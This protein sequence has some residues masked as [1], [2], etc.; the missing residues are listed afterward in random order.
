MQI[1]IETSHGNSVAIS[2]FLMLVRDY[3]YSVLSLKANSN[4]CRTAA[5][6]VS[7]IIFWWRKDGKSEWWC[8]TWFSCMSHYGSKFRVYP[9]IS[10]LKKLLGT[11]RENLGPCLWWIT[12]RL[13][14]IKQGSY[15]FV[16]TFPST[17]RFGGEAQSLTQKVTYLWWL[18]NMKDWWAFVMHVDTWVMRRKT[19]P[20][21]TPGRNNNP[22]RMVSGWRPV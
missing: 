9:S 18:S 17:T 12:S 3:T 13:S 1:S 11:S 19:A 21:M 4:G 14:L 10:W 5:L 8:I 15:A 20:C 16:S 2:R 22:T 7:I 6:G